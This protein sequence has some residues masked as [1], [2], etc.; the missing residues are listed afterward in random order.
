MSEFNQV[1]LDRMKAL[2]GAEYP[3]FREALDHDSEKGIFVNQN[4]ISV[5]A[6][7]AVADFDISPIPYEPAGFYIDQQRLGRH[8]LHHAGAFY[9]QDPSAMFTVNS[10]QFSGEERVLDLCA[11]PGGK[12]VQIAS[13]IPN[14][15]LVS[16][17]IEPKRAGVLFSNIERM[18]LN[19]VVISNDSPAHLA[20]AYGGFFDVVL[21][22]AP[23]SGEGMFRRGSD[24]VG[25]WNANLPLMCAARQS[26]ILTEADKML[27][28]GGRLIYSTCTYSE[29]E[30]E[31]VVR[32]F[33][34]EHDYNLVRIDA[35]FDR[36]VGLDEA[37]RLYPH[38]VKGEGQF[39][40]VLVKNSAVGF[41]DAHPLKL[42]KSN[43]ANQF[44]KT[45]TKIDLGDE[46]DCY[47]FKDKIY[48]VKDVSVL[49]KNINYQSIGVELGRMENKR[50]VPA[51]A[52]F[53]CFGAQFNQKIDFH[54]ASS[55]VAKYLRGDVID[56]DMPDG[57]GAFLINSCPVG[58]FKISQGSFKNFYPIG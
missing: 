44:L 32:A 48:F 56:V 41:S 35:P 30:N 51:H 11:A 9:V 22:D 43:L 27:R 29:S 55:E 40:A 15:I 19:N 42:K 25:E 53:S 28:Q 18:G 47:D 50:F 54:F 5:D 38:K 33:L 20:E 36:G 31:G 8:P 17:E 34:A 58:G 37:V 7:R 10:V 4:K 1:F 49:R 23:C 14:G 13:R 2:L 26:Q 16:N 46:F 12:S 21:V 6:F 57:F 24:Y 52:L 45:Y 39:V 3:A